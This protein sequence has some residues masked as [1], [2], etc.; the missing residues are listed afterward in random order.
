MTNKEQQNIV[1]NYNRRVKYA[2]NSGT[3]KKYLPQTYKLRELRRV[4][5]SKADLNRELKHLQAFTKQS[6]SEK[7][8]VNFNA[9][10]WEIKYLTSLRDLAIESFE[11]RRV[12]QEN[13]IRRGYVGERE[14]LYNLED[15]IGTLSLDLTKATEQQYLD[16]KAA[17]NEFLEY[18]FLQARG[19]RGFLSEVDWVMENLQIPD[20]ERTKFFNKLKTLTPEQFTYLYKEVDLIDRIY[21]LVDSPEFGE[22][23]LNTSVKEARKLINSLM[24]DI[25]TYIKEAKA[26]A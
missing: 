26:N 9:T 5:K 6:L 17:I 25:D 24:Q 21:D 20:K 3:P 1:R 19:Y 13:R 4:F 11:K 23:K 7:A 15:K 16:Y 12:T 18:P 2:S 14:R 8:N 10:K 22:I